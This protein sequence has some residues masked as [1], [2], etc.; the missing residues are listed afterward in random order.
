MW[1]YFFTT[2]DYPNLYRY[3][4]LPKHL[5]NAIGKA[6]SNSTQVLNNTQC[7]ETKHLNTSY[8]LSN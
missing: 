8:F 1:Y 5:K 7:R 3:P 2:K 4:G 6:K